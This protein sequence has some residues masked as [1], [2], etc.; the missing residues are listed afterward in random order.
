MRSIPCLSGYSRSCYWLILILG[1]FFHIGELKAQSVEALLR[2]ES[3]QVQQNGD[4]LAVMYLGHPMPFLIQS[5]SLVL[6]SHNLLLFVS[7]ADTTS[8]T[9]PT[10]ISGIRFF[11][12]PASEWIKIERTDLNMDLIVTLWSLD[13]KLMMQHQWPRGEA[14]M[15]AIVSH[16]TPGMY[17]LFIRDPNSGKMNQYK[18]VKK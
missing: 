10:P 2:F 16:F 7:P 17:L 15:D 11:P 8:I 5:D 18:I 9:N 6:S 3:V 13:A 4:N 14:Q 1:G 12:N